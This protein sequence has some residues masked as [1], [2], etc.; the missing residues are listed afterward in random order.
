MALYT[1]RLIAASPT[2]IEY[3]RTGFAVAPHR[4]GRQKALKDVA[5]EIEDHD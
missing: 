3:A 4:N 5:L 2:D 1:D